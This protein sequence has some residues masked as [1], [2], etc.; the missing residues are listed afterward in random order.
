LRQ[1]WRQLFGK[2][3]T[4][5]IVE[6]RRITTDGHDVVYG[7]PQTTALS[8]AA[9]AVSRIP[10]PPVPEVSFG[11]INAN[12][13]VAKIAVFAYDRETREPVWQSGNS[14]AESSSRNTWIFGIGPI[15]RGSIY[16]GYAFAGSKI[17][18][19]VND[20]ENTT[21]NEHVA[22]QQEFN[23][24]Q[25]KADDRVAHLLNATTGSEPAAATATGPTRA[26]EFASNSS[27][28]C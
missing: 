9:S 20:E 11:R 24:P 8:T 23:F 12:L 18:G 7:V 6:P 3:G 28:R 15:Q 16:K 17:A 2:I 21:V 1:Q 19:G 14:R 26:G 5:I 4:M 22:L 13:G 27:Q 10:L 25:K